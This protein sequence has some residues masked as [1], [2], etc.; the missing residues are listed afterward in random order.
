VSECV[1]ERERERREGERGREREREGERESRA[2]EE[3]EEE[4]EE[5]EQQQQQEREDEDLFI[6]G[7]AMPHAHGAPLE[8]LRRLIIGVGGILL[9]H[10]QIGVLGVRPEL[11]AHHQIEEQRRRLRGS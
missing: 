10:A 8:I 2:R 5:E 11:V 1:C 6:D 3:E 4:E 9:L 7:S